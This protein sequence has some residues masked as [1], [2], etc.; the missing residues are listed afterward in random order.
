MFWRVTSEKGAGASSLTGSN[1]RTPSLPWRLRATEGRRRDG[2]AWLDSVAERH[3]MPP[4]ASVEVDS[5]LTTRRQ[6]WLLPRE[7]APTPEHLASGRGC[8]GDGTA[9]IGYGCT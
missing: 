9:A 1:R 5:R 3:R 2:Q 8:W 4:H 6:V 7:P